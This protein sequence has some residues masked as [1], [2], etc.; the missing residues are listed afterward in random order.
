MSP[1]DLRL[2]TEV[3]A[4]SHGAARAEALRAGI[5]GG[6]VTSAVVD[7]E[8]ARALLG[9]PADASASSTGR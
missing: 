1:R 7:T 3:V 8:L 6:Y 4:V 5:K 9:A 2:I